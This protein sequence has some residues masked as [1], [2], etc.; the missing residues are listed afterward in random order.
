VPVLTSL[1]AAITPR[2]A[3]PQA[4]TLNVT[5]VLQRERNATASSLD[6]NNTS[7]QTTVRGRGDEGV[8]VVYDHLCP[9][10]RVREYLQ[11]R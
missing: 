7:K 2:P 3:A 8:Y 4:S 5:D 6:V 11:Q 1:A 10:L 9:A